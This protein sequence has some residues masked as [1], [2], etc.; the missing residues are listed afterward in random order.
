MKESKVKIVLIGLLLF[1]LLLRFFKFDFPLSVDEAKQSYTAYSILKTGKDTNQ[2]YPGLF[3]KSDNNYLS[4]IAV[5]SEIPTILIFGLT[6]FAVKLPSIIF[7]VLSI[8]VFLILMIHFLKDKIQTLIT[9][10]LFAFSPFLIQINIFDIG[11]SASLFFTLLSIHFYIKQKNYPFLV[12]SLLAV[13]SNFNTLPVV[14][15]FIFLNYKRKGFKH[16]LSA[17]FFII[18]VFGLILKLNPELVNYFYR[19]TSFG[20]V[21]PSSYGYLIDRRLSI[22]VTQNSPLILEN[23]NLNRIAYN[24]IFY[25]FNQ[26]FINIIRPFDYETLTSIYQ[27][28]FILDKYA[29]SINALPKFFFWE[30]PLILISL[31]F[32]FSKIPQVFKYLAVGGIVSVAIFGMDGFIFILPVLMITYTLF[33]SRLFMA[34]KKKIYFKPLGILILFFVIINYISFLDLFWFHNEIWTPEN[35]RRQYQIWSTLSGEDLSKNNITVT[36]RVGEPEFYYLFYKRID[37]NMFQRQKVEGAVI[38]SGVKR[39]TDIGNLKFQSFK[40]F[41]SDRKPNQIWVGLAGEFVGENHGYKD[42]E[43]VT[44]GVIYKKIGD[45]K[46]ENKFLGDELWFVRTTFKDEKN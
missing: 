38:S 10:T 30:I 24:K 36:D 41:E 13:F 11:L 16:T 18:L 6:N 46:V 34:L 29:L 2:N 22:G 37:P 31:A 21:F 44:D 12:T 4:T 26:G 7:G 33:F 28:R 17:L 3:F 39:I 15:I 32:Y 40:Y 27:A 19:Q 5:Y 43:T 23:I 8:W 1:S 20:K 45:V 14:L 9:T 25:F 35:D 42:K